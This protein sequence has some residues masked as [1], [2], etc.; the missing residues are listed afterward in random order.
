MPLVPR[1]VAQAGFRALNAVVVPLVAR[2]LGNPLPV[3]AGPVLVETTG[4]SSGLPRRVP[5]LS[6]RLGD[7]LVVSTVR[8]GRSQWLQNLAADAAAT[9]SLGGA[10]RPAEATLGHLGPLR[11]ATLHLLPDAA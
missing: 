10:D 2:G 3:G 5:L 4:R 9:V 1:P 8:A 6:V 11:T 7:R